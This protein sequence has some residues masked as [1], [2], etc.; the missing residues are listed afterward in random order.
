MDTPLLPSLWR[1]WYGS[2]LTRR[3]ATRRGEAVRLSCDVVPDSRRVIIESRGQTIP[4]SALAKLF[5][6]FSIGEALTPGW[7]VAQRIL[8]LFGASVSVSNQAPPGIR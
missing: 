2:R 1:H 4:S 5:D 6:L 8:S 7:P 3:L